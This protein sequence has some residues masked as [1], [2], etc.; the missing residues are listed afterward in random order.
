[1][2]EWVLVVD[3]EV[4]NLRQANQILVSEGMRVS[5]AKSGEQ[6]LAF[7]EGNKPD[8]ILM[9]VHMTGI[10][11]FE[12]IRRI[13]AEESTRE[14]PI[15]LLTADEDQDTET[16]ALR[17]GAMDFIKKPFIPD[18]LILRA[19]HTIELTRLQKNLTAE[20]EKKTAEIIEQ[21]ERVS[22]M[23]MQI[24][25]TL[26]G[27][28]DIKDPYTKGH[29]ER[30]AKYAQ[31]IARRAGYSKERLTQMH[32]MALF[33]DIGKLLIPDSIIKKP[34]K[35]SSEE[36]A[37]IKKHPEIG[38]NILKNITEIPNIAVGAHWHHE[39]YD[40]KGYPD[41]LAGENIPEEA[42]IIAV[43][44]CYDAITS[45]RSY[46]DMLTQKAVREKIE[47]DKGLQFD[48]RFADIMLAII[49]D[50]RNYDLHE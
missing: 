43:A 3:D 11:G 16:K 20:V 26:S 4:T 30:V 10:D 19:K 33:H 49:D 14:I 12:T 39:R 15:I 35:L 9:D 32:I 27:A 38:A 46:R 7:L 50:D 8:L 31:E 40:G 48:P 5:A 13:K 47:K 18:V 36:Y 24:V 25:Q 45:H 29:S 34:G 22:R 2:D 21:K 28:I 37:E 42:R 44:D 6:A 23:A 17:A 1:M 41:G